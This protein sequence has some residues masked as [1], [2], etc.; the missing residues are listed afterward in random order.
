MSN[1]PEVAQLQPSDH[2]SL[3]QAKNFLENPGLIAQLTNLVGAPL[4]AGI[5]RLPKGFSKRLS[6]TLQSA[7]MKSA[8]WALK[9]MGDSQQESWNKSHIASVAI[10]GGVSGFFGLGVMAIEV[11]ITTTI[12]LRSIA[13]IGRSEGESLKSGNF[14]PECLKVFAL[15]GPSKNDDST[16]SG[17]YAVRTAL[18]YEVHASAQY[19]AKEMENAVAGSAANA[20]KTG[21]EKTAPRLV[22]LIQKVAEKLGI[23]YSEKFAAQIIPI[24][25]A[26]GGAGINA[27]F[28]SHFQNMARGHFIVR[29]LERKYGVD[30]IKMVYDSLPSYEELL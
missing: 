14:I 9:T 29:R 17:Y 3:Q 11:P 26:L 16:E 23:T 7:L 1:A 8:R 4:E 27:I 6:S 12:I 24:F 30:L 15:G 10:T 20:A 2:R 18:A 13:D 28:M 19:V 5:K 25:G 22:L 21:T